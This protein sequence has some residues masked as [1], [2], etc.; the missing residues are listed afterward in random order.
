MY[1]CICNAVTERDIHAA[2][3]DGCHSMRHLREALGVCSSCGR[4]GQ[5]ALEVLK[6]AL[7][8]G[9]DCGDS[10]ACMMSVMSG[11]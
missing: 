4:C 1:I 5:S 3:S 10:S 6:G 11:A 9:K 7:G 2:V 8:S